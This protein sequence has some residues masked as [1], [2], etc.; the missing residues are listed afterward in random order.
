MFNGD[1]KRLIL[2]NATPSSFID[3]INFSDG[4]L[5]SNFSADNKRLTTD[6]SVT[7]VPHCETAQHDRGRL[8]NLRPYRQSHY[9]LFKEVLVTPRWGCF[10]SSWWSLCFSQCCLHIT[11]RASS[12]CCLQKPRG[13]DKSVR[14]ATRYGLDGPVIEFLGGEIFCTCPDRSWGQ[15]SP[16]Y[17][18]SRFFPGGKAAG[19]WRWPHI[20]I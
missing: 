8:E 1:I 4:P 7:F 5:A 17:Y 6:F 12:L 3:G 16:L 14:I 18:D 13:R 2:R 11:G 15:P 19:A 20:P 9:I 10:W